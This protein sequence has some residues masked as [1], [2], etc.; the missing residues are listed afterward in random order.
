MKAILH[1]VSPDVRLLVEVALVSASSD[2][3]VRPLKRCKIERSLL[4]SLDSSQK[5]LK[6]LCG[7]AGQW[8]HTCLHLIARVE[9]TYRGQQFT[10]CACQLPT[11]SKLLKHDSEHVP[12]CARLCARLC[13]PLSQGQGPVGNL[14]LD[15]L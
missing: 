10:A 4:G 15:E 2:D 5:R 11:C 7:A 8:L 1:R 13:L 14:S 3:L 6:R 12:L 9:S